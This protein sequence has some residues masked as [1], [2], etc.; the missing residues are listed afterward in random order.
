MV[1]FLP[2][3][4]P[5]VDDHAK[6]AIGIGAATLL[7]RQTRGQQHHAPQQ[8]SM[9]GLDLGHRGNMQFGHDQ[10]MHWCPRVDVVKGEKLFIFLH[11][12]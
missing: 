7:Q 2:T 9:F 6:T 8:G 1:D 10:K 3:F 4:N 12:A 11:F 5:G